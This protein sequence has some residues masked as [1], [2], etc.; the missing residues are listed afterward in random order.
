MFTLVLADLAR[1]KQGIRGDRRNALMSIS[2]CH[3]DLQGNLFSQEFQG[4]PRVF[5]AILLSFDEEST[6]MFD[7]SILIL[8][9]L[10]H[11]HTDC[12]K[13]TCF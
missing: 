13:L 7:L 9:S 3:L 5:S 11:I 4:L 8:G 10:G 2:S 1:L 6:P 12:F